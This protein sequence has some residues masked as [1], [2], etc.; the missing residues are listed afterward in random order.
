MSDR[1]AAKE[2]GPTAKDKISAGEFYFI[3]RDGLRVGIIHAC[4][5]GCGGRSAIFFRGLGSG[6]Q[7]WDVSGSWPEVTLSPSIGIRYD[8]NGNS[9]GAGQY[10]WHGY[11][12]G[13]VFEK[14]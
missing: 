12:K 3:H 14:C 4:P 10:H 2:I 9:P 13:G 11:L 7:E 5:C 1:I 6:Q 8:G